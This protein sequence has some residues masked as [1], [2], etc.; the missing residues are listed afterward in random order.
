V[1]KSTKVAPQEGNFLS[2][3]HNF[4]ICANRIG[5]FFINKEVIL[6]VR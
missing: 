3:E 5:S 4:I 6:W 2:F 1:I